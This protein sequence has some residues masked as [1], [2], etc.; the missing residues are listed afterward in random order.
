MNIFNIKYSSFK[1]K[2]QKLEHVYVSLKL[3]RENRALE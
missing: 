1:T 3:F 2:K